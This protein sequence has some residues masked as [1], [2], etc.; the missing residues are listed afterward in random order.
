MASIITSR[1][2]SGSA[3]LLFSSIMRVSSDWSSEPQ[4]TPMRTGFWFSA[5]HSTMYG[6]CRCLSADGCVAGIDAVLGQGARGGRIFLQQQVAVVVEIAD[7]GDAMPR[8]SRPSTMAGTAAAASSLFTVTRTI[9]EPASARAA[10]CSMVDA[11]RY[12]CWSSI[13]RR[14]ELPSRREPCRF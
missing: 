4:F 14:R 7:D 5:A 10:T 2:G 8:L 3:F 9:S 12:R 11:R 6:S 1:A 13:A